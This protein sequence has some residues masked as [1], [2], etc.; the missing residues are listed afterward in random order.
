MINPA[1]RLQQTINIGG[2][3]Y[4][5]KT[6]FR[7]WLRFQ[8]QVMLKQPV[9]PKF[10]FIDLPPKYD[11]SVINALIK[12]LS[13]DNVYPRK[14]ND[15]GAKNTEILDIDLINDWDYI[16]SDFYKVY[17]I[18]LNNVELHY[19]EFLAL[20][21]GL[22]TDYKDIVSIRNYNGDDKEMLKQKLAWSVF[23][24]KEEDKSTKEFNDNLHATYE[25]IKSNRK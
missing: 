20:F 18:N 16:Y 5:I 3:E 9:I 4:R 2:K 8:Q 1:K 13:P 12:F 7:L 17:G 22:F 11:K 15:V 10:L 23:E 14:L 24:E 19:H 25:N 6:D 21:K